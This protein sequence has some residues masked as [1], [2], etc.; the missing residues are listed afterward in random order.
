[1][2]QIISG[3]FPVLVP[4]HSLSEEMLVQIL[5]EPKNSL[6]AQYQTL[7]KMDGVKLIF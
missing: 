3:R 7:F 2:F 1:M 5:V 6:V 4:F